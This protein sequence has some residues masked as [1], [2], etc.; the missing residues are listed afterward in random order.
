MHE[1][2]AAVYLTTYSTLASTLAGA[3]GFL[4]AV[5]LFVMQGI[6][7]H[8]SYCAGSLVAGSPADRHRLRQ[9]QSSG[10]WDEIVKLHALAGQQS[11][12][13]S[14]DDNRRM[15]EQFQEMRRALARLVTLRHALSQA[16]Y[17]TGFVILASIISMP[18]TV[19]FLD[20]NSPVAMTL[21]SLTIISAMFCIRGYFKL[22]LTAVEP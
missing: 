4:V 13:Q 11:P 16:M 19:F 21:L 22:M 15:D 17:L 8:I 5:V 14:A 9:L 1:I 20:P 10:K 18:L 3:F 12:D 2:D 6:N 7:T